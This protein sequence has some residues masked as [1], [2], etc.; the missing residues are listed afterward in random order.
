MSE[1]NVTKA[2]E[3]KRQL[4]NLRSAMA[5]TETERGAHGSVAAQS[6]G[7]LERGDRALELDRVVAA[8]QRAALMLIDT[9][10]P[11]ALQLRQSLQSETG[12]SAPMIEWG[13]LTSLTSLRHAPLP[14]LQRS[15]PANSRRELIGVVLAGNVFVAALRALCLPLLAGA[16]VLAKTA[17]REGAFA[18]A[19]QAALQAADAEIGARLAV[20]QFPREDAEAS[21]ALCE[22]VDALSVYGDDA[23]IAQLRDKLPHQA[24]IIAHGHG[25]SAAYV[26]REQLATAELAASTAERV[27]LD[28]CAYDQHGCLSPHFVCVQPGGAVSPQSF[29][30]LLAEQAMP[31][32]AQL[33][34]P[35]EPNPS[36]MNAQAARL[37]WQGIAAVRGELFAHPTHAVSFEPSPMRPSPGGRLVS[38]YA[39]NDHEQL[40][41]LLLPFCQHLKCVGVAG[42]KSERAAV[43]DMLSNFCKAAV[44]MSG[45]MQTPAFD[46]WADGAPPLS[47]LWSA[48]S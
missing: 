6:D 27:A 1:P 38:V 37:Q 48:G 4:A 45:E 33:L 25:I 35:A 44:C 47:G 15:L 31:T 29:A 19:I 42:N 14:E 46:A 18:Q 10:E 11:L 2:A 16:H 22:G 30:K 5:R 9:R 8:L 3:V 36:D 26:A 23:T 12:L 13:L 7:V 43:S 20:V 41:E 39:C 28:I 24:R 34:P 21:D 32:L 17:T 40:R